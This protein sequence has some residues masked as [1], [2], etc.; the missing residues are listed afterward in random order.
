MAIQTTLWRP[1]TCGCQFEYSW[2]DAVAENVRVHTPITVVARCARHNG[3]LS[4]MIAHFTQVT[5]ENPRK[6]KL[7]NRA[8]TQFPSMFDATSGEFRGSWFFDA[9]HALH[10]VTVGL[11]TN[12][13]NNI[14]SWCDTNLGVGRVVIE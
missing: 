10:V 9:G 11:S 5:D 7:L 6:N 1:D 8:R 14:Q 4:N 13:K 12:Q 3:F 2:D